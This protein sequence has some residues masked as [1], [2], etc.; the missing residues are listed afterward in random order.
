[1]EQNILLQKENK[2]CSLFKLID[3]N[4][5]VAELVDPWNKNIET[6]EYNLFN[7]GAIVE[8]LFEPNLTYFFNTSAKFVDTIFNIRRVNKYYK[9]PYTLIQNLSTKWEKKEFSLY[10]PQFIEVSAYSDEETEDFYS[11]VILRWLSINFPSHKYLNNQNVNVFISLHYNN[12]FTFR[13]EKQYLENCNATNHSDNE[14][15]CNGCGGDKR[16]AGCN[17]AG[18][19]FN[20]YS[21]CR[22][23]LQ[24]DEQTYNCTGVTQETF[25][26]DNTVSNGLIFTG[27]NGLLKIKYNRGP[28]D[29]IFITKIVKRKYKNLNGDWEDITDE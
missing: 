13:F 16:N 1:M 23:S 3:L 14:L 11:N 6:I 24:S 5:C 8:N 15:T 27:N 12:Q 17:I 7:A 2:N 4:S 28:Y 21:L 10:Y 29:D 18:R 26:F 22:T 9:S 19:C 25:I 20:P